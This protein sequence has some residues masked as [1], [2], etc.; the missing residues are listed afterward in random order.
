MIHISFC[1]MMN[2]L[3]DQFKKGFSFHYAPYVLLLNHGVKYVTWAKWESVTIFYEVAHVPF[4][5]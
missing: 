4:K 2:F 5:F 1:L 3:Y